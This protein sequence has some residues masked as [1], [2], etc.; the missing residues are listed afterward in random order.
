MPLPGGSD[1]T[2][3]TDGSKNKQ[4]EPLPPLLISSLGGNE[5]IERAESV[6]A[7][8]HEV[9]PDTASKP[10]GD[11]K[12][13]VLPSKADIMAAVAEIEKRIKETEKE[14]E[15][16]E[17]AIKEAKKVVEEKRMRKAKILEE[18]ERK[19]Q[20]AS[21][22]RK[23]E[24]RKEEEKLRKSAELEAEGQ[25]KI[26][27]EAQKKKL[28][29]T[30]EGE[31][32][33]AKDEEKSRCDL[34][35]EVELSEVSASLDKTVAKARRDLEKSKSAV[36]KINKK[37]TVAENGYKSLVESEEKKKKKRKKT[38]EKE[39]VS[40][41]DVVES[42]T[43]ENQRKAK[44]AQLL[45]LSISDPGAALGLDNDLASSTQDILEASKDPKYGKTFEEWSVRAKQVT[46]LSDALY[47]EPSETPF[48]EQI[49]RNNELVGPLVKEYIRDNQR[50]LV[51][52][53]TVLAEE[54]EVR[55]RL[56]EKQQRKLAK[57]A[58]GSLTMASKRSITG[59]EKKETP[60]EKP[61]EPAARS[62]NNP[63]R[64][65]RRGNE[66]RS[67][68]EQEQ[69]IAEIAAKEAMERRITHGGSKL[70]RQVC[71]L[72]RVRIHNFLILFFFLCVNLFVNLTL[73][74]F[75]AYFRKSLLLT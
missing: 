42:V 40:I 23:E 44:E 45:S 60:E 66:V 4:Q 5:K 61:A 28:E 51:E 26:L 62:S 67:E 41:E 21:E 64:R 27:F 14:S 13:T 57:K 24:Q 34:A 25:S 8:L 1:A 56:Y 58:R 33:K 55:R 36:Q 37:L 9:I 3:D 19:R 68:Y 53:W 69:I 30:F 31:L 54:Y 20:L 74:F 32:S 63:Y 48:Y 35:F 15:E 6:V 52:H 50:R 39:N 46:G 71:P 2:S 73:I 10:S 11:E 72:E 49:E 22:K 47:S 70:P 29:E 12:L 7:H 17:D 75:L 65:A 43:A 59:S 18:E 38:A 16:N